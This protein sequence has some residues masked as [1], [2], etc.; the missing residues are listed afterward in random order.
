MLVRDSWEILFTGK[1]YKKADRLFPKDETEINNFFKSVSQFI[2]IYKIH[3]L[4]IYLN[5]INAF[6]LT[7]ITLFSSCDIIF[8]ALFDL[9]RD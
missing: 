8:I 6:L 7:G 4:K 9:F 1:S 2:K 5:M 3:Y